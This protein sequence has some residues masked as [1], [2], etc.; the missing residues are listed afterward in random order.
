MGRVL[1]PMPRRVADAA[2]LMNVI[3]RADT[4]DF[5]SLPFINE[6]FTSGLDAL[7]PKRLKI[8]FLPDM[9]VGLVVH[10]ELRAAADA[11]AT[12]LAGS[13]CTVESTR[14]FLTE[15]IL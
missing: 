15:E 8:G 11:A 9:A 2:L 3:A 4:R 14:S 10:P 6:D 13:A 12:A 5:M 7:P 1:G